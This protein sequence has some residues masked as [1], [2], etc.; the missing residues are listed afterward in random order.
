MEKLNDLKIR[1]AL[2][3]RFARQGLDD[4]EVMQELHVC[5]SHAIAD[6]VTLRD[7]SHCYE[8][9][10]ETDKVT[11]ILEQGYHY[12][13]AFRRITLVT[14]ENH[15]SKAL[16]IT[17]I[18][19]GV[20]LARITQKGEVLIT[21]VRKDKVNPE[22][23]PEIAL[24]T[25]WKDELLQLLDNPMPKDK[26]KNCVDLSKMI[27]ENNKKLEVSRKVAATLGYRH[28]LKIANGYKYVAYS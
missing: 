7:E 17:P 16:E 10:G 12:N 11:R 26:R 15:L 6:V 1:Q 2:L 5:S 20:M 9:K 25:L 22:F 18:F 23:D 28:K 24:Y 8:I 21:S 14:T 4:Y 13:K 3:H 19:W 27:A